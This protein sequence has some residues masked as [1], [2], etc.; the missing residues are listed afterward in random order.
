MGF[1]QDAYA[2]VWKIEDKGNYSVGQV[3]ISKK[4]KNTD[5]YEIEFQDGFVRFVGNAHNDIQ[6]LTIPEK[7]LT[8]KITSCDVS[9]AY[10]KDKQ[11][12]YVNYV[13]F[14]FE[15]PNSNGNKNSNTKSNAK[16][17]SVE[18]PEEVPENYATTEDDDLPF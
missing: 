2:K 14:G 11:K 15:I 9:N 16:S 6:N 13:I 10:V 12:T 5:Q 8:I 1:R 17:N 18:L 3:S 7:G 4:N